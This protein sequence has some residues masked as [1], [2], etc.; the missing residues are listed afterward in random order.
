MKCVDLKGPGHSSGQTRF[1]NLRN[2]TPPLPV[3]E[4]TCGISGADNSVFT[5][6]KSGRGKEVFFYDCFKEQN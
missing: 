6:F 4:E 2:S 3:I 1:D 5:T